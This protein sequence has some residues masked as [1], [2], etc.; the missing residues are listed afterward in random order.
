MTE[1]SSVVGKLIQINEEYIEIL[2]YF[3]NWAE[4]GY[5]EKK[6]HLKSKCYLL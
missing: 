6:N 4:L 1:S 3:E 2:T 5:S